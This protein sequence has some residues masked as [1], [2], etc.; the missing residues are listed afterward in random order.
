MEEADTD[1]KGIGWLGE[2]EDEDRASLETAS[3]VD[4]RGRAGF[5]F[6]FG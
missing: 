2:G 3:V 6:C 4:S 1:L 5:A